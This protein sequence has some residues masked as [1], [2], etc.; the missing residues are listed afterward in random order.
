MFSFSNPRV[1]PMS[2]ITDHIIKTM[3]MM[4]AQGIKDSTKNT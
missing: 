4:G 3:E 1:M 2:V